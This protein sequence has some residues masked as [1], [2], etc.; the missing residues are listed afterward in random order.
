MFARR[1]TVLLRTP[2]GL[3]ECRCRLSGA[4]L[5]IDTMLGSLSNF[6]NLTFSFIMAVGLGVEVGLVFIL[7]IL[8]IIF[9]RPGEI[10]ELGVFIGEI[11]WK[12]VV[13][14]LGEVGLTVGS[15]GS[16]WLFICF[17]RF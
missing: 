17:L 13:F 10:V 11:E 16:Y 15:R 8:P 6:P 12:D 9:T 7:V 4:V 2:A 3:W 5:S 14:L 1:A